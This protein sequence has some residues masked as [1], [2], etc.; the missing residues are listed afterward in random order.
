MDAAANG[1]FPF[2]ELNFPPFYKQL[3]QAEHTL[4][5]EINTSMILSSFEPRESLNPTLT[6]NDT[7]KVDLTNKKK[8]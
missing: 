6:Q 5:T 1:F 7:F 3:N 4:T 8:T 2:T